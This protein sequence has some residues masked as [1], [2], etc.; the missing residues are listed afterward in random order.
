MNAKTLLVLIVATVAAVSAAMWITSERSGEAQSSVT[1]ARLAPGLEQNINEVNLLRVVKAG[2]EVVAEL[3][4]AEQ[5]WVVAS[6]H[7]YLAA[8]GEVRQ[9]LLALA[10]AEIIEQKTAKAEYYDRLGVQDVNGTDATGVRLDIEGVE[11][12]VSLIIGDTAAGGREGTYV[13]PHW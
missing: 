8:I 5:G 10:S 1:S 3:K 9:L 11:P 4:P 7:D 13:R 6:K 12:A 2:S